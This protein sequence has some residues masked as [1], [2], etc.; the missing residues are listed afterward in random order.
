MAFQY[1]FK[2]S[3]NITLSLPF[4]RHI[5]KSLLLSKIKQII[6]LSNIVEPIKKYLLTH[7]SGLRVVFTRNRTLRD[8]LSNYKRLICKHYDPNRPPTCK[9]KTI[10]SCIRTLLP[11]DAFIE[12]NGD[13]HI[14]FKSSRFASF[15]EAHKQNKFKNNHKIKHRLADLESAARILSLNACSTPEP[16]STDN[17]KHTLKLF[18]TLTTHLLLQQATCAFP[19]IT[20]HRDNHG[21]TT[22]LLSKTQGKT[23]VLHIRTLQ[24]R[25]LFLILL[26]LHNMNLRL[27]RDIF[28]YRVQQITHEVDLKNSPTIPWDVRSLLI[29]KLDIDTEHLSHPLFLHPLTEHYTSV[30]GSTGVL[31]TDKTCCHTFKRVWDTNSMVV[32]TKPHQAFQCL[33][34]AHHSAST[35]SCGHIL[36]IPENSLQLL[37]LVNLVDTTNQH[38]M[39]LFPAHSLHLPHPS[40]YLSYSEIRQTCEPI[41]KDMVMVLSLIHI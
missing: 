32:T 17:E 21:F 27:L 1:D 40:V 38:Q 13:R 36:L 8:Q 22:L 10:P 4:S 41:P 15:I 29:K 23:K 37:P 25:K 31:P 3:P 19:L 12:V 20:T 34:F 7:N 18:S 35:T 5:Q 14:A 16:N 6:N 11:Q 24:L 26:H 33:N 9:C 28:T 30:T 39:F 2:F